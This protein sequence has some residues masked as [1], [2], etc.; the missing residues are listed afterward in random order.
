MNVDAGAGHARLT[1][2]LIGP[3]G[4]GKT[5]IGRRLAA[6]LNRPLVDTDALIVEREG[7]SIAEIFEE[8]SE[9]GFRKLESEAVSDAADTPDA[10]IACGGGA[11][12]DPG[13]VERLKDS[14]V[15]VYLKVSPNVAAERVGPGN[16]RPLL[17]GRPI[18]ERL[19]KLIA[20][21]E[22]AY[23]GAADHVVDASRP[24]GDV[25]DTLIG[26]WES[27]RNPNSELA[28]R[29]RLRP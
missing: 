24:A 23:Q 14:G 17:A 27:V 28:R 9:A 12:L 7:R 5:E 21:R 29:W 3:S 20:E 4:A 10:V 15:V 26:I 11:V 16:S 25:V 2:A 13:N 19:E 8:D 6:A 18:G 1:I 22:A